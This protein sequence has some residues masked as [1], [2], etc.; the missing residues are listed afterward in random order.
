MPPRRP[1]RQSPPADD[2]G[3]ERLRNETA[4]YCGAATTAGIGLDI[5]NS[6]GRN[7]GGSVLAVRLDMTL[8]R[9]LIGVMGR[10]RG[11]VVP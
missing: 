7:R 2:T 1:A 5:L 4:V 3:T 9:L 6:A 10:S 8:S 11:R